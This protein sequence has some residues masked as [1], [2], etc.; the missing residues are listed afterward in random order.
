MTPDTTYSHCTS[1]Y[2]THVSACVGGHRDDD[3][4]EAGGCCAEAGGGARSTQAREP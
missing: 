2:Y 4:D 1:E 3:P